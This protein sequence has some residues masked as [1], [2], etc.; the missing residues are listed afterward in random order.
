MTFTLK[1]SSKESWVWWSMPVIPLF[2]R[3][4]QEDHQFLAS[5][6]QDHVLRKKKMLKDKL[7]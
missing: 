5:L 3:L 4:R 7:F 1:K 6:G 2:G